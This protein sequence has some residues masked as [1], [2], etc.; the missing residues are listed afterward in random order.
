MKN[1]KL[2]VLVLVILAVWWWWTHRPGAADARLAH[3]YQEI[4]DIAAEDADEP[5]AG[6]AHLFAYLGDNAPAMLHDA[7]SLL[8]E[9]ERIPDDAAHD[10]RAREASA[11]MHAP[12]VA[13]A[14][15]LQR[16]AAAVQADPEASAALE[17]GAQRFGRT[18]Q[19]LI[20][21]DQA[22]ADA[23]APLLPAP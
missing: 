23:L 11:V 17:R 20:G 12:L 16:F 14:P 19:L 7:G 3:R 10:A 22:L 15:D 18:L 8:V 13:C 1:W 4:C 2:L 6:V 9:I 5:R 21:G